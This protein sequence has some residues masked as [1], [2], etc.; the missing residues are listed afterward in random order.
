[1]AIWNLN[2]SKLWVYQRVTITPV[3]CVFFCGSSQS[4]KIFIVSP[5][6]RRRRWCHPSFPRGAWIFWGPMGMVIPEIGADDQWTTNTSTKMTKSINN[7]RS[8]QVK[9]GMVQDPHNS[10]RQV[11]GLKCRSTSNIDLM[12][13]NPCVISFYFR[14]ESEFAF[15]LMDCKD[16]S[17]LGMTNPI[18]QWVSQVETIE[19]VHI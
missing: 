10:N 15:W 16:C 1:M 14:V 19:P 6:H 7:K 4:A 3:S 8:P 13:K 18:L 12:K 11:E 9:C 5:P 17:D 2:K